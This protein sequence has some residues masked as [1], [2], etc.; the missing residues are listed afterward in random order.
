MQKRAAR[1]IK[2]ETLL[3]FPSLS[4]A[5][6]AVGRGEEVRTFSSGARVVPTRSTLPDLTAWDFNASLA[7][8]PPPPALP[9]SLRY[10]V[11]SRYDAASRCGEARRIETIR[12]P[13]R[14]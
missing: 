10:D 11:A 1:E 14:P 6:R 7:V 2:N 9:S 5:C 3:G 4:L 13:G 8:P 12:A